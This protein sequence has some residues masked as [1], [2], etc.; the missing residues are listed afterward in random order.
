MKKILLLSILVLFGCSKDSAVAPED[1]IIGTHQIIYLFDNGQGSGP[2]NIGSLFF[3]R[4]VKEG[5]SITFNANK[6]GSWNIVFQDPL[7]N[8]QFTYER[9]MNFDWSFDKGR[10]YLLLEN[11]SLFSLNAAFMNI[12]DFVITKFDYYTLSSNYIEL[13]F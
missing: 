6:K 4:P 10:W 9:Q 11:P 7:A 3:N 2:G 5:S 12:P 8:E 13:Y 1:E